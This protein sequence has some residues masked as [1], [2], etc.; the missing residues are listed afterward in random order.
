MGRTAVGAG[1]AAIVL[2]AAGGCTTVPVYETSGGLLANEWGREL[3]FYRGAAPEAQGFGC[4]AECSA[5]WTPLYAGPYDVARHDY[6]ILVRDDGNWQWAYRGLPIYFYS[7]RMTA[8]AQDPQM[9]A[10]LWVPLTR[11]P[12]TRDA[13]Q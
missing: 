4:G 11:S 9:R 8:L 2:A 1:L 12:D 3:F 7:G 13:L 10:G 5:A 6:T